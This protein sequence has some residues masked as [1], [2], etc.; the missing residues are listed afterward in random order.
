MQVAQV[1]PVT[2]SAPPVKARLS[3]I[4]Q[5]TD[6]VKAQESNVVDLQK[7]AIHKRMFEAYN[8]CV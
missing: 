1:K 6:K 4:T 7:Q 2:K 5:K 8:D 3:E